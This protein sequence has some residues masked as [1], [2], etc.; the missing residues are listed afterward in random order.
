LFDNNIQNVDYV[1]QAYFYCTVHTPVE[2]REA[3]ERLD[4]RVH[5]S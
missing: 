4:R 1:S 2:R 5:G 3:P